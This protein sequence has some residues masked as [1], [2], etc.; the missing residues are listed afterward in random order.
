LILV[1]G[2]I[3]DDLIPMSR[4]E[5]GVLIGNDLVPIRFQ[6][7]NEIIGNACQILKEQFRAKIN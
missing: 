2:Q 5:G 3:L 6:E 7:E 1:A 4:R